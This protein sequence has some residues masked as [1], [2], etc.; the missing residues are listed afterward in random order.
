[1]HSVV[2]RAMVLA[3]ILGVA[4]TGTET[5]NPG[6]RGCSPVCDP[7]G[8]PIVLEFPGSSGRTPP[9]STVIVDA[10]EVACEPDE[11][12]SVRCELSE[13]FYGVPD[14][15]RTTVEASGLEPIELQVE[16]PANGGC[17][18][19]AYDGV[20]VRIELPDASDG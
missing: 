10:R 20:T 11:D 19:C 4:C 6:P 1:M 8:S 16:L 5:G 14:T 18:A 12:G 13:E 9:L 17:C 2:A 3:T 7:C 15:Y